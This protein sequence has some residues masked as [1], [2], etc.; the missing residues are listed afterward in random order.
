VGGSESES[1]EAKRGGRGGELIEQG[2]LL[3]WG[4]RSCKSGG[5]GGTETCSSERRDHH[6]GKLLV[7]VVAFVRYG[8]S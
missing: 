1:S 7:S 2:A 6:F 3:G 4:A 5:G 8:F